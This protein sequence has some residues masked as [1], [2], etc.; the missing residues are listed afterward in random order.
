MVCPVIGVKNEDAWPFALDLGIGMQITN[1]C[2]DILEDARNDRCYLPTEDLT[3]WGIN[4][5]ELSIQGAASEPLKNYVKHLITL[6]DSYYQSGFAGLRYIPFRPRLAILVAGRMYQAIGH[7]ILEKQGEVL[8]GRT[9]LT[10]WEKI[11]VSLFALV[12]LIKGN[13]STSKTHDR[14]LH[15]HLKGLP[16]VC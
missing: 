15:T 1:I 7:K 3:K 5:E 2:R 16:G 4:P 8:M 14:H 10:T 6:A 12:E 13:F 9:Y 11:K